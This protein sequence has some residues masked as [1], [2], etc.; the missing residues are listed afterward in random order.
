MEI[1]SFNGYI[2]NYTQMMNIPT[3]P[4]ETGIFYDYQ[5]NYVYPYPGEMINGLWNSSAETYGNSQQVEITNSSISSSPLNQSSFYYQNINLNSTN[6]DDG[7]KASSSTEKTTTKIRR[8]RRKGFNKS[9]SK[10]VKSESNPDEF[11]SPPSPTVMKKR[12]LAAN[13]R[14]R[15][16][17][18][19]LNDAFNKL[20]EVVPTLGVDYKL[21]KYETLQM[22][23]TYITAMCDLLEKGADETTYTLFG[24][25]NNNNCSKMQNNNEKE[26]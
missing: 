4:T 3:P 5:Q 16:R 11:E 2:P 18:N 7:M 12:R 25:N 1:E 22:A 23:Q 20:R 9:E 19:E 17:M 14:E 24:I 8:G 15:R 13:A 26:L 10:E 6:S 21:S